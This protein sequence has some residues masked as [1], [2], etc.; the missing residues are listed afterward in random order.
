MNL[1]QELPDLSDRMSENEQYAKSL[2]IAVREEIYKKGDKSSNKLRPCPP[3][4]DKHQWEEKDKERR[5]KADAE[6]RRVRAIGS[7]SFFD[8]LR[9]QNTVEGRA[10]NCG[11]LSYAGIGILDAAGINDTH[12][13]IFGESEHAVILIGKLPPKGLSLTMEDW[14]S[15]LAICDPWGNVACSAKEFIPAYIKKMQKWMKEGK[16]VYDSYKKVWTPAFYPDLEKEL[17]GQ[18]IIKSFDR[19]LALEFKDKDGNTPLMVAARA[20]NV[21]D[22]RLLLKAGADIEAKDDYGNTALM[23]AAQ[24]GK[25]E[26]LEALLGAGADK[27]AKNDDGD[28]ALKLAAYDGQVETLEALLRAGV[29]KDARDNGGTT[30]LMVAAYSGEVGVV[31]ALLRAGADKDVK[32]NDGVN[33]LMLAVEQNNVEVVEAL[34]RAGADKDVRDNDGGAALMFAAQ[35]AASDSNDRRLQILKILLAANA[36]ITLQ[37]EAGKTAEEY[38]TELATARGDK[39]LLALIEAASQKQKNAN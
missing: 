1:A 25:V 36:N 27:D 23:L 34:L 12:M 30:A 7:K 11:D 20:G 31:E 3:G 33:A 32:N 39:E 10:H 24:E 15:H 28:T 14:P 9:I 29:D 18:R 13:V 5:S 16:E 6:V 8:F 22:V 26:A 2:L 19:K 17:K 35:M 37:D 4:M 21:D 38:V